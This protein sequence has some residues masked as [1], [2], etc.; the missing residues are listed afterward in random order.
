MEQ[1]ENIAQTY[2]QAPWRK[3]LQ[4]IGLFSLLL[5]FIALVAGIYLNVSARTATLGREIQSMQRQILRLDQEIEDL[6]SQLAFMVS[7]DAM[8]KRADDLGY[9]RVG[10]DEV[11]Y[12][13]VPGYIE[14]QPVV[15]APYSG[16]SV[17]GATVI[18]AEYTESLFEWV[19][20]QVAQQ[21]N[22]SQSILPGAGELP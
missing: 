20:R 3:Q 14:R 12:V 4:M 13:A 15:L 19:K 21:Q 18:P 2:S 8:G 1:L 7:A 16:R 22:F 6:Q 17:V 10:P 11:L 5:V 9:R